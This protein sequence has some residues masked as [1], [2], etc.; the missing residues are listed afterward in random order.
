[1]V[2]LKFIKFINRLL[3]RFA[4]WLDEKTNHRD[5]AFCNLIDEFY[6]RCELWK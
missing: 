6:V 4:I 2:R 5:V 1:M 3:L